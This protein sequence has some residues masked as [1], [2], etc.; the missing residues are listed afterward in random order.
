M[1]TSGAKDNA[2][3][4]R[5]MPGSEPASRSTSSAN[6]PTP[7]VKRT[8]SVIR[9]SPARRKS[10]R[11]KNTRRIEEKMKIE[12]RDQ[13]EFEKGSTVQVTAAPAPES[14]AMGREDDNVPVPTISPV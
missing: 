10:R 13:W 9:R 6:A 7:K 8:R 3:Q 5:R 1:G 14:D 2:G 11:L 4:Q 12:L